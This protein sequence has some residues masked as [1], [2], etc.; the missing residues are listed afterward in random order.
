[1]STSGPPYWWTTTAF[2]FHLLLY[3]GST[4][5]DEKLDETKPELVADSVEFRY[6]VSSDRT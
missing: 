5:T 4:N 6:S 2:I 3:V 1:L